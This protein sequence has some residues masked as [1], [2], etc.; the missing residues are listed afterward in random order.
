M[1][2]QNIEGIVLIGDNTGYKHLLLR[3]M[4]A[5][6]EECGKAGDNICDY[7]YH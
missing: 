7:Q 3:I 2:N 5:G 6:W 1:S 4:P